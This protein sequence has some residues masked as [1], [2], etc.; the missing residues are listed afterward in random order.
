MNA[1]ALPPAA[2]A[3]TGTDRLRLFIAIELPGAIREQ[4]A[5]LAENLRK[6]IAF[7]GARPTW[8]KPEAMHLTLVFLGSQPAG[9]VAPVA[10]ALE[11]LG[12]MYAPLRIELK[13]LGVFPHWRGPRV[14]WV[15]V[16]DRTH[17]LEGLRREL[18]LSLAPVGYEPDGRPFR[19]HLTLA[20]FKS[21]KGSP[22]V[23]K[24]VETHQ[25]F[26]FGPFVAG[27]LV[28]FQSELKPEGAVHTALHRTVLVAPA[29][30]RNEVEP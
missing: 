22:A 15:G 7:T 12:R 2:D 30:Y 14:L 19:P 4:V 13:R 17:Q 6:G 29:P 28:L 5:G 3:P 11:R 21:P 24:V 25:E 8:L 27:E 18:E 20:R 26:L 10:A 23:K 9:A 1:D 16:R